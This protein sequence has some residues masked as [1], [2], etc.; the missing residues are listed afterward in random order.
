MWSKNTRHS[1]VIYKIQQQPDFYIRKKKII[2]K[3]Y[4][5]SKYYLS[6]ITRAKSSYGMSSSK[7]LRINRLL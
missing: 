7:I 6:N 2:N 3:V 5:A 4:T 1:Q